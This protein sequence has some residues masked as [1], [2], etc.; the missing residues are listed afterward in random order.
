M[1]VIYLSLA[2]F[3][4]WLQHSSLMRQ[5]HISLRYTVLDDISFLLT[6]N[7]KPRKNHMDNTTNSFPSAE[8]TEDSDDS[9]SEINEKEIIE[10]TSS[11]NP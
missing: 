3:S 9:E 5:L 7:L 11:K 6:S 10:E 8:Y 2:I 1:T 4:N